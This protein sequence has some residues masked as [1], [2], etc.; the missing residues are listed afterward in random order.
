MEG[1]GGAKEGL[2]QGAVEAGGGEQALDH[3]RPPGAELAG[4][5][6]LVGLKDLAHQA[7]A[8]AVHAAA[9][10]GNDLIAGDHGAAIN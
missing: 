4:P 9:G 1:D 8:I 10:D 6:D 7:E 2:H 5:F 3:R